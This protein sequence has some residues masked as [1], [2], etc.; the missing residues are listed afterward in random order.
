MT[1]IVRANACTIGPAPLL[2][3]SRFGHVVLVN[4]LP[5]TYE[6]GCLNT[7]VQLFLNRLLA[8]RVIGVMLN[9]GSDQHITQSV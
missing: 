7:G 5:G 6:A 1:T 2:A 8:C 4:T 3:R 9:A